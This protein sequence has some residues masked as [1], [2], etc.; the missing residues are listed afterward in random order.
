MLDREKYK[1]LLYFSLKLVLA[2]FRLHYLFFVLLAL[3]KKNLLV[4]STF[5]PTRIFCRLTSTSWQHCTLS[6]LT[7]TSRRPSSPTASSP[8]LSNS[9]PTSSRSPWVGQPW[10]STSGQPMGGTWL[11]WCCPSLRRKGPRWC[12]FT[13]KSWCR[14]NA[15]HCNLQEH[16]MK[17]VA[18]INKVFAT[19]EKNP[20]DQTCR[21]LAASAV[22]LTEYT[23]PEL[24][25]WVEFLLL[26]KSISCSLLVNI[27]VCICK[28]KKLEQ[29]S[30]LVASSL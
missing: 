3:F 23:Y 26:G 4:I 21:R 25:K 30:C 18:F 2:H 8:P 6:W 12:L 27:E 7:A 22:E 24:Y 9:C 15:E 16:A 28:C 17:V 19:L 14:I 29:I 11:S 20:E 10:T 5:N 1:L 13:W